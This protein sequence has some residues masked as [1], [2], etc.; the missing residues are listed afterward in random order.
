MRRTLLVAALLVVAG[1]TNGTGNPVNMALGPTPMTGMPMAGAAAPM[2]TPATNSTIAP[3]TVKPPPTTLPTGGTAGS[4]AMTPVTPEAEAPKDPVIPTVTGECPNLTDGTITFM[5]LGGIQIVAGTRSQG[6]TA[7]MVFY[8]HGT[9][10][11]SGEFATMAGAVQQGVVQEG[12]VLVS[13]QDSTGGDL[14][15]GTASFGAGDFDITDQLTA[16]AVRDHNIEPHR[17]FVTGCSAGGLFSG[18]MAAARSSY[19]AAAAPSSGGWAA[20]VKFQDMH[21]PAL[22]T[23]HGALNQDDLIVHF[24]DTSAMADMAFKMRGGFVIDCDHGGGHCGGAGLAPDIWTFFKAHPYGVDPEPWTSLPAGF[25]AAC[26]I[27]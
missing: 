3:G 26:M 17:I 7:P 20:P 15:S 18:A 11:S 25:N 14:L 12:G 6:P 22:M 8:W 21:T 13:F 4:G 5:G 16:C 2:M 19:I 24:S 9:G 23:I 27:F 10:S 1:C